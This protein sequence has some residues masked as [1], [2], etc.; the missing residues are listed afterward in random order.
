MILMPNAA[1]ALTQMQFLSPDGRCYSFDDRGNGYGRGEGFVSLLIKPVA[2]A[3]RDGDCIRAVVRASASNQNGRTPGITM[4]STEAQALLIRSA[5][6][7]AGLDFDTTGYFEAHGTG[8]PIGDP[9]E[10][11]AIAQTL[12][13]KDT[14]TFPLIVGSVKS[15]IGHLEGTAGLAGLVKAILCVEKGM[16][17]P[18][19]NFE[20]T[21]R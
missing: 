3:V 10:F 18:L 7:A 9:L 6:Q 1:R 2:A 8:T 19:A 15:N 12:V 13:N 17:P 16:I 14:R 4:P 5:Y 11:N 20:S 21:L